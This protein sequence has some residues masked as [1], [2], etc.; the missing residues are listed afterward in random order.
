MTL[1]RY[2][3]VIACAKKTQNLFTLDLAYPGRAMALTILPKAIVT[4]GQAQA[5]AITG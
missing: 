5:M 4:A 1:I 2:G 3:K